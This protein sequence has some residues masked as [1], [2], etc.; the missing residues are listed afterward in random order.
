MSIAYNTIKKHNGKINI[1]SSPGEGT[2]FILQIPII[3]N[4]KPD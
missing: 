1:C 3:F 4:T 2:K